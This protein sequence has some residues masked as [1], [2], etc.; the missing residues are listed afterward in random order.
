MEQRTLQHTLEPPCISSLVTS[1]VFV[2]LPLCPCDLR[3]AILGW[4]EANQLGRVPGLLEA[5]MDSG[6]TNLDALKELS[7]E[8]FAEAI[9]PLKLKPKGLKYKKLVG[10]LR[11]LRGEEL[12]FVPKN[13]PDLEWRDGALERPLLVPLD[14]HSSVTHI[15]MTAMP[16][17]P[18]PRIGDL[19]GPAKAFA[20]RDGERR[21]SAG[22]A[23]GPGDKHLPGG[24][25]F[26]GSPSV[27][28]V[29]FDEGKAEGEE[30]DEL[31]E[32]ALLFGDPA[33]NRLSARPDHAAAASKAAELAEAKRRASFGLGEGGREVHIPDGLLDSDVEQAARAGVSFMPVDADKE[34]GD[35]SYGAGANSG[36]K[37]KKGTKKKASG[38]KTG[39]KSDRSGV[40]SARGAKSA[41]SSSTGAK[42]ARERG[43]KSA[44]TATENDVGITARLRTAAAASKG[45]NAIKLKGENALCAG[46][47]R[48][49]GE[50]IACAGERKLKL[51]EDTATAG[52]R[53]LKL[54]EDTAAAGERKLK[55]AEN[56]KCAG[57]R[58]VKLTEKAQ[59]AGDRPKGKLTEDAKCAGK[60]KPLSKINDENKPCAGPRKA[61]GK[62]SDE[63]KACR[64]SPKKKP[65]DDITCVGEK[66]GVNWLAAK[67]GEAK[68]EITSHL[69][70]IVKA[71]SPQKAARGMRPAL[72]PRMMR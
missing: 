23:T 37:K 60:R 57:D 33:A 59:C 65:S 36:I 44:R 26:S 41:R 39:A 64:G 25:G 53:K 21:K 31:D 12:A 20:M 42:S 15:G 47:R 52:E 45:K 72:A 43:S 4:L 51:T 50:D 6:A 69:E 24:S 35:P 32:L 55:L 40:K 30:A 13:L 58:K 28:A 56:A 1:A 16:P 8:A 9:K 10:A 2:T 14:H 18:R 71:V 38:A 34:N 67:L 27:A 7:D 68:L 19:R 61:L 11:V 49:K 70:Q 29:L 17:P 54:T 46:E 63:N 48:V 3:R 5:L 62:L 66:H 22:P